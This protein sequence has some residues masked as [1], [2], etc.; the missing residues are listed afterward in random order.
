MDEAILQSARLSISSAVGGELGAGA[1][2]AAGRVVGALMKARTL[3]GRDAVTMGS[4]LEARVAG[5]LWSGP[6][7]RA[8]TRARGAPG[9]EYA[10]QISADATRVYRAPQLKHTGPN[11]GLQAANLERLRAGQVIGNLHLVIRP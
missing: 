4:Q 11:A 6:G 2:A 8:I 3:V 1:A 9:G 10:G 5:R 7:S